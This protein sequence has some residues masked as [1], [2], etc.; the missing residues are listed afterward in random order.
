[1][2]FERA[3]NHTWRKIKSAL[4]SSIA[5]ISAVLVIAPLGLVFFHLLVNGAGS[6][7]WDFFTR[8]PAP[9]GAIGGG[10]VNAI[11]GS[12]EL[13]ALAGVIGIPIGVL[14]GV[15]LA[16]YGS[17]RINSFLRFLADVLNGIPSITWGIVVYGLVVLRFKGF[18]AYAG[19]L[20]LG[21]IMIPLILRTT[22]EVILLVPNG[23]RE[24]ALALGVSRWKTIVHIVMKTAS[25]GIITGILLALARVGGETAPLLFTAFGNRFWNHSLSQPIAALPLQVFTYAISPYDDWHR[26][27]WAGALVLVTGV[28]CVNV[29]VRILTRGRTASVV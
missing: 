3:H 17:A 20:A 28:F 24:A 8:L 22:E 12:L 4:A 26:Q 27:A 15:Y 21:L 23:Y 18:S 19:G 14:G 2:H 10:M 9:V 13:L 25:K 7:N 11:V 1:M 16:E 29:L 6:V 5:F